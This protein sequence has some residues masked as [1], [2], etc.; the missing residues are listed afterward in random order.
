MR[1]RTLG[2]SGTV[3]STYAL[4]TMTFGVETDEETSHA[5]LDSYLDVGGN[6]ID[7]A[8]VYGHGASEEIVGSWLAKHPADRGR[9]VVATKGRLGMGSAPND[10]GSSRVHLG[11]ALDA[12]LARLGVEQIDLY[13]MH[14]WDPLT[15]LD[16]TLRFLSDSVSNGKIAH[17]GFSNYV[18]WE[19][20]KAAHIVDRLGLNPPSRCSRNTTCSCA[21]SR[22]RSSR[23]ASTPDWASCRGLRWP[24]GG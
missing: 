10:L 24:P 16:E 7:T 22:P 14:S 5:I 20:A 9:V 3:V 13:Q 6:L 11:R 23:R 15:P 2:R 18:G 1:Y 4:G 19:I 21:R 17:F 12:S 8:D